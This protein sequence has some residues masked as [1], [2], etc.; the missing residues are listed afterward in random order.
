VKEES[1]DRNQWKSFSSGWMLANDEI[2]NCLMLDDGANT[3]AE[4]K[5][6]ANRPAPAKSGPGKQRLE[7]AETG[8]ARR[9]RG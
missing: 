5:S 2:A 8:R 6:R 9:C 7:T 1:K 4:E 3:A